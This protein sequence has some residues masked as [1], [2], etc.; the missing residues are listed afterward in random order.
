MAEI[1]DITDERTVPPGHRPAASCVAQ[2][3]IDLDEPLLTITDNLKRDAVI[4]P[5][6]LDAIERYMGDIL[7]VVLGS[8]ATSATTELNS[9][10]E[11]MR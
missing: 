8:C 6:E 4:G 11:R 3:A 10:K 5:A 2:I 7:D 9:P 1:S